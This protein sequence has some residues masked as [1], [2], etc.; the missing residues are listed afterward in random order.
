[1]RVPNDR[2]VN[3]D[4]RSRNAIAAIQITKAIG[5]A[6]RTERHR[7]GVRAAVEP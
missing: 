5:K 4:Q 6:Q 2:V 7:I 3:V 1:M